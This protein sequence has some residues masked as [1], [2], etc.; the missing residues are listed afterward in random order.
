MWGFHFQ[1]I[2]CSLNRAGWVFRRPFSSALPTS[3]QIGY[4]CRRSA[5][6]LYNHERSQI[7]LRAAAPDDTRAY[8]LRRPKSQSTWLVN[9]AAFLKY[10]GLEEWKG[11]SFPARLEGDLIVVDL[12]PKA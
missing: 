7:G 2:I 4:T 6:L 3:T 10:Y 1:S 11:Q 9:A 5:V 12:R 8:K